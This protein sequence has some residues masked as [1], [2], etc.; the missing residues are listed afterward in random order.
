MTEEQFKV[1]VRAFFPNADFLRN[2]DGS[3]DWFTDGMFVG[4][5]DSTYETFTD[6]WCCCT[7][8]KQMV[9]YINQELL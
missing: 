9:T 4:V 3:V 1:I 8:Q 6:T 2:E 5:Y 7:T